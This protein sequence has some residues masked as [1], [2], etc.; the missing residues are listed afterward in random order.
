[1]REIAQR[2]HDTN[3]GSNT[4]ADHVLVLGAAI[5]ALPEAERAGHGWDDDPEAVCCEIV[6]RADS[7]GA[8]HWLAEEAADRNCRFSLGYAIDDRVRLAVKASMALDEDDT[9]KRPSAGGPQR[10]RPTVSPATGPRWPTSPTS[11]TSG[12][13]PRGPG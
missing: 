8:T 12:P 11:L 7:G 1:M 10:S 2:I 13:G 6:I 4:A 5:D 9:S 3:A